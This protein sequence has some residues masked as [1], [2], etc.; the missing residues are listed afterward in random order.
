MPMQEKK[1]LLGPNVPLREEYFGHARVLLY[2][3]MYLEHL[4]ICLYKCGTLA[5]P[6]KGTTVTFSQKMKFIVNSSTFKDVAW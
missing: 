6:I 3:K 4:P 5:K 1:R 2:T